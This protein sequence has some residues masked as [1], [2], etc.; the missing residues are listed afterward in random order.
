MLGIERI[1]IIFFLGIAGCNLQDKVASPEPADIDLGG[2]ADATPVPSGTGTTFYVDLKGSDAGPGTEQKPWATIQYAGRTAKSGDTILIR[3][4]EYN[5][6]EIWLRT[7]YGHCGNKTGLLTIRN[8]PS[9][10]VFLTNGSRPFI[11]ECD[12]LRV[13]GLHF[14]NGKSLASRGVNRNT[15]QFVNNTF[16]GS[17]YTYDAISTEGSNIL[18]EGNECDINGNIQGTQG[19]C[20]YIQHGTNITLRN[21]I[22]KGPTGY[23]IHIFD[24]R[25]SGDPPGFERLIQNVLV[26]GNT[27]RNSQQRA[28]LIVAAYDH[29]R[30][31][32][33]IIRNNL[34]YNNNGLGIAIR[35]ASKN[36]R[37]YNNTFF[38]NGN[39]ALG[40]YT[41]EGNAIDGVTIKNNIFVIGSGRSLYHVGMEK[42]SM[43]QNLIVENNFY[44][45]G[46]TPRLEGITDAKPRSGSAEFVNPD[47]L[48]LHLQATSLAIDRGINLTEVLFDKDGNRR[49]QGA[50]DMGAYEFQKK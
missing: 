21:N 27:L 48:D 9:E 15:L 47:V 35:S 30:I 44:G 1:A 34:I 25:R 11:A 6:G 22:T 49:P 46:D 31:E 19:H 17:G 24:Q 42:T 4:G 3:G 23:G 37:V 14:R 5:E 50:Y 8:A 29:A 33:V 45:P 16:K 38:N 18:I 39:H 2:V 10:L 43:I 28:G 12:Y 41:G 36:I 7:D 32:N 13:Q 40:I 20:Y 26:E